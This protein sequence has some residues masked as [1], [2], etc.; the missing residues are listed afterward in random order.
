MAVAPK[1]KF[2]IKVYDFAGSLLETRA[3]RPVWGDGFSREYTKESNEQFYRTNLKGTLTLVGPDYDWIMAHGI[4]RGYQLYIYISYD[5][6][7]TWGVYHVAKFAFFDAEID[8]DHKAFSIN[9]F[10]TIDAYSGILEKADH[11]YDLLELL[12]EME[13]VSLV[14]RPIIQV[15]TGGNVLGCILNRTYWEIPCEGS[16]QMSDYFF[17]SLGSTIYWQTWDGIERVGIGQQGDAT[18]SVQL[19][20]NEEIN[21]WDITV[22]DS[23]TG[24]EW[25]QTELSD[26]ALDAGVRLDNDNNAA[27]TIGPIMVQRKSITIGARWLCAKGYWP[28]VG[29]THYLA[30]DVAETNP[31]YRFA[32]PYR[33]ATS[34]VYSSRLVSYP[35]KYGQYADGRYYAP[36][37]DN[38]TFLPLAQNQWSMLSVWF[39]VA[40]ID[41]QVERDGWAEWNFKDAIPIWSAIKVLLGKIDVN[42][43]HEGTPVYSRFLY[44]TNPILSDSFQVYL[45]Q[46]SNLLYSNHT[47]PASRAPIT[48]RQLLDMLRD[49]FQCYW[50]IDS[51]GRFRIEHIK[52]FRGGGSYSGTPVVGTNL[53]SL[54]E[55]RSGKSLSYATAKWK[56]DTGDMEGRIEFGWAD[57]VST[58][59]VGTPI[60]ITSAYVDKSRTEK[61]TV[62]NFSSD[63][64]LMLLSPSSFSKEGFGLIA[65]KVEQSGSNVF[66]KNAIKQRSQITS[67]GHINYDASYTNWFVSGAI[68]CNRKGLTINRHGVNITFG[69]FNYYDAA[70][71]IIATVLGS[72]VT[73]TTSTG[74]RVKNDYG[75]A[76][77][78]MTISGLQSGI[79]DVLEI[80]VNTVQA[81]FISY[82]GGLLQNGVLGFDYLYTCYLYDLSGWNAQRDGT[83]VTVQ[84]VKRLKKQQVA[85]PIL[86]DVNP[87]QLIRTEIGNGEVEKLSINLSSRHCSADLC[88]D[89]V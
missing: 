7:S 37:N 84:G 74:F 75:A 31:N 39:S 44:G 26:A 20:F 52:F 24:G 35:T 80:F 4:E 73:E 29:A 8:S 87:E 67:V 21:L 55:S 3:V 77:I 47:Q 79:L 19:T 50:F 2:E 9:S 59:F 69:Y 51:N 18:L 71:T 32:I 54:R 11:E 42:L 22:R 34:I 38:D 45:T 65:G 17:S 49:V 68:S 33:N 78:R 61:I 88:Y 62:Q 23:V 46:K 57:S 82:Q 89:I 28:G 81:P 1:Y 5:R 86:S 43:T 13:Q 58:P 70:G 76:T 64:D 36:P 27:A 85:F 63:V 60:D 14:K 83:A 40:D 56:Y 12:P 30:T 16:A 66:D 72:T 6:G 41:A 15:Y 25:V 48:L 53:V 10:S